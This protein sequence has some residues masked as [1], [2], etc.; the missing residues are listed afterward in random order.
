[1]RVST[2][3]PSEEKIRANPGRRWQQEE[4]LDKQEEYLVPWYQAHKFPEELLLLKDARSGR[5]FD[6]EQFQRLI[7]MIHANKVARLFLYDTNRAS[8]NK[9]VLQKLMW[10]CHARGVEVWI[11]AL[12][13]KIDWTASADRLLVGLK[14]VIDQRTVD[15][16]AR[17][18]RDG[19]RRKMASGKR[20]GHPHFGY[21]WLDGALSP[22]PDEAAVVERIFKECASGRSVAA[23]ARALTFD[24]REGRVPNT[25]F[26]GGWAPQAIVNILR[27]PEYMGHTVTGWKD[28]KTNRLLPR[29]EWKIKPNTHPSIVDEGSYQKAREA[30]A[31]RGTKS[32]QKTGVP[33]PFAK[34]LWCG[35]HDAPI[36]ALK[37]KGRGDSIHDRELRCKV[38]FCPN[39]GALLGPIADAV[40]AGV[41]DIVKEELASPEIAETVMKMAR[42]GETLATRPGKDVNQTVERLAREKKELLCLHLDGQLD[43]AAYDSRAT[44]ID[45]EMGKLRHFAKEKGL[46]IAATE[47]RSI[48]RGELVAHLRQFSKHFWAANPEV[49][50]ILLRKILRQAVIF[51]RTRVETSYWDL[52]TAEAIE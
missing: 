47:A 25:R 35:H 36:M 8:R 11:Y 22:I 52:D 34:K 17:M 45:S 49:Q 33:N 48:Q 51:E 26:A 5:R 44:R 40:I 2:A 7:G 1:M 39:D 15:A 18:V 28:P 6:R 13:R 9:Q 42:R 21:K 31:K 32:W 16:Q 23:I 12:G 20:W 50:V 3:Q 43:A 41:E 27:N 10:L 29:E 37:S 30:L 14:G 19:I 24:L 4:S 38:E 46:E